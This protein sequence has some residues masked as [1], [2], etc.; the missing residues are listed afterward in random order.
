MTVAGLPAPQKRLEANGWEV[1][2][3]GNELDCK[4]ARPKPIPAALQC[5]VLRDPLVSQFVKAL[6]AALTEVTNLKTERR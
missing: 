1:T 6:D 4:P 2:R 3:K 5:R